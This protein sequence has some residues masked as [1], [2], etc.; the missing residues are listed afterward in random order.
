MDE[1]TQMMDAFK[2]KQTLDKAEKELGKAE[3]ERG[4]SGYPKIIHFPG[5]EKSL[6]SVKNQ[7]F[8]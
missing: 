1:L 8:Q 3:K 2:T 7:A 6:I 5:N 4:T